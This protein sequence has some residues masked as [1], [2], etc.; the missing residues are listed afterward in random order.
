MRYLLAVCCASVTYG[1]SIL[2]PGQPAGRRRAMTFSLPGFDLAA[3]VRATLAE[4]LG[5]GG[6]ITSEAVIPAGARFRGVMDSRDAVVVAGLPLAEAFFRAL[7][8]EV[9]IE[10]LAEAGQAAAA[11]PAPL[12]LPGNRRAVL[13]AAR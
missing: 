4:D 3:F 7:D 1:A 9:E 6:D 2:F 5:E 10:A 11:G 12:R 8:P 13:T